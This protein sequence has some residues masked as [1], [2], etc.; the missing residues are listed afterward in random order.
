MNLD[1]A[2]SKTRSKVCIVAT[3]GTIGSC[4]SST[5]IAPLSQED[6]AI[7]AIVDR[8]RGAGGCGLSGFNELSVEITCPFTLLSENIVPKDWCVIARSIEEAVIRGADAVV[9]THGTDTM[10]YSLAAISFVM[11]NIQIPVVFTGSMCPAGD[12]QSDA[13]D[14]LAGALRFSLSACNPGIYLSFPPRDLGNFKVARHKIQSLY[15]GARV[16]SMPTFGDHFYS[17]D[18]R[19]IA[20]I[21]DGI[22]CQTS[23]PPRRAGGSKPFVLDQCIDDCFDDRVEIIK[24]YPG[25][26]PEI[27]LSAISR[28][29]QAII[30]DIYH[31]GTACARGN[32]RYSIVPAISEL[33]LAGISVFGV[34]VP[35]CR[36]KQYQSTSALVNCGMIPLGAITLEAAFVKAMWLLGKGTSSKDLADQMKNDVCGE[37]CHVDEH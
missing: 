26:N 29:A 30:L 35:S 3:G 28:K 37:F 1:Q 2:F 33:G 22:L 18:G 27:L 14:N 36:D 19:V 20:S 7:D 21:S 25:F 4:S 15:W 16:R 34:G 8:L 32:E 24:V 5:G 23:S 12:P 10:A 11:A 9:V 13:D 17:I 31:S 6:R